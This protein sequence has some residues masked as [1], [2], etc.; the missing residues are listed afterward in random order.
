MLTRD[1]DTFV[2]T[3]PKEKRDRLEQ[4]RAFLAERSQLIGQALYVPQG[5]YL[6]GQAVSLVTTSSTNVRFNVLQLMT[7]GDLQRYTMEINTGTSRVLQVDSKALGEGWIISATAINNSG[8][9]R[10]GQLFVALYVTYSPYGSSSGYPPYFTFFQTYIGKDQ[11]VAWHG[12]GPGRIEMSTEGSGYL[13]QTNYTASPAAGAEM[14]QTIPSNARVKFISM[15]F[16]LVTDATVAN[17]IVGVYFRD[18]SGN[19]L[20][21]SICLDNHPASTTRRYNVGAYGAFQTV[22]GASAFV[23]VPPGL[24]LRQGSYVTTI[25]T[26]L[27]A[28]DQFTFMGWMVEEFVEL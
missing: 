13:R 20:C 4:Y 10:R 3:L 8:I 25:T 21:S 27:Q 26:N 6:T 14:V 19:N 18:S 22:L 12:G 16:Q 28:G 2:K 23:N 24:I 1:F 5:T 11:N 9:N 17:R 7:N 15:V